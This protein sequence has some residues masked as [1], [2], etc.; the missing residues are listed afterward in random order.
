MLRLVIIG[1]GAAGTAAA[2]SARRASPPA[3]VTVIGDEGPAAYCRCLIPEVLAGAAGF[4][5]I[6]LQSEEDCRREGI[7]LI[8]G[9]AAELLP[10]RRCVIL[11][12]GREVPYDRLLVATGAAPVTPG[13]PGEDLSGIFGFRSYSDARAAAQATERTNT[14]VVLGGGLVSLKAAHALRKRGLRVTVAVKSPH[15][16]VRQ[17]DRESASHVE[18]IFREMGVEFIFGNDAAEFLPGSSGRVRAVVLENGQEVPA[19]LVIYGKGV[20]PRA[21]LVARAGGEVRR[22]IVVDRFLRTSL[23]D[24]YAA[25]DCAEV[26]DALTGR[27][28]PSG[29]WPLAVEQGRYAGLCMSGRPVAYPPALT[30]QN[31]VRFGNLSVIS[32][33]RR[34]AGEQITVRRP[35]S[36]KQ[37]FVEDGR[38]LGYVL[39]NDVQGAGVYTGLVRSGRR[40]PGLAGLLA[41]DRLP[42]NVIAGKYLNVYRQRD[43]YTFSFFKK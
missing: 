15:L 5:R 36:L 3:G 40:L 7:E 6:V 4:D 33:G 14:A 2:G 21:N 38:L 29:L 12:D 30:A 11:E 32:A 31:S 28:V 27:S 34:D 24:V 17:L 16:M 19:G 37:F 10:D 1:N 43:S 35:G 8:S 13:L 22:G 25:G 18:K 41:A 26:T 42:I 9:R 23:P 39:V 20:R